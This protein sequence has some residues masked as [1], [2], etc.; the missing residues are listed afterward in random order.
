M[1][2]CLRQGGEAEATALVLGSLELST[3]FHVDLSSYSVEL[4]T[5]VI[6]SP[7]D[8][9]MSTLLVYFNNSMG[10]DL[11][12]Y[13]LVQNL[14]NLLDIDDMTDDELLTETRTGRGQSRGAFGASGNA[15]IDF[16]SIG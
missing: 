13:V 5:E 11:T 4:M 9:R 1:T 3:L 6:A 12:G 7:R 16:G 2:K 10:I 8:D 15:I 14:M